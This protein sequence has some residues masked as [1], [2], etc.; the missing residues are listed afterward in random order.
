MTINAIKIMLPAIMTFL[1]GY[2][3]APYYIKF[4]LKHELWKKKTQVK[5]LS[6]G[7]ATVTQQLRSTHS[8]EISTPRLGGALIWAVVFIVTLIFWL[9]AN[10]FGIF[11]DKIDFV[12]R[13]QTWI[14]IFAMIGAGILGAI[15]DIST[16]GKKVFLIG[17]RGLSFYWRL[18]VVFLLSLFIS[19]WFYFK[20]GFL[21]LF[22]PFF[23]YIHVGIFII[24]IIILATIIMFSTSVI[25]GIDGLSG[26]LFTT[27]FFSYGVIAMSQNQIDIAAF[28]FAVVGAVLAFLWYNIS[29]AQFYASETGLISLAITLTIIAFLTNQIFVLPIIALPLLSAPISGFLQVLSKKLRG[30][31][32]FLVA[33]MHHHFQ[34]KGYKSETVV[35]R[36]WLF[37]IICSFLGVVVALAGKL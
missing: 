5:A 8:G 34:A 7:D 27:A 29:P 28:C 17:D 11:P 3:T 22:I 12:S 1:I 35:M 23:G 16:C 21:S 13:N 33:P 20:L 24:P 19:Y 4:L 30:K 6:G 9:G 36:Y 14:I 32:I 2:L 25:D 10:F 26:G 18:F 31:K 37:A 15:D